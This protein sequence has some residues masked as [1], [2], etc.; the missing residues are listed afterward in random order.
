LVVVD[1]LFEYPSYFFCLCF[2]F[3]FLFGLFSGLIAWEL[4]LGEAF[5]HVA[6]ECLGYA[7]APKFPSQVNVGDRIF[8]IDFSRTLIKRVVDNFSIGIY[9]EV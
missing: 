6:W 3:G 7:W 5:F 1:G 4:G 8:A 2:G 9:R